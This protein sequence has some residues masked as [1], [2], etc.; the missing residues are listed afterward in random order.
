MNITEISRPSLLE[1]N[2]ANV[3]FVEFEVP[4]LEAFNKETDEFLD[5][6]VAP[7]LIISEQKEENK[8][9]QALK[10]MLKERPEIKLEIQA[11]AS[12]LEFPENKRKKITED[13]LREL[14]MN[15][16]KKVQDLLADEEISAERLYILNSKTFLD[17]TLHSEVLFT[18]NVE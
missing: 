17:D 9:F 11:T 5:I 6:L 10:T 12:L 13:D 18:I 16:A 1:V 2:S 3:I 4:Y 14:S 7:T 8:K 15:R